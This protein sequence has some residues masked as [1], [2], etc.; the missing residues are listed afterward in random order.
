MILERACLVVPTPVCTLYG[1]DNC[2]KHKLTHHIV[3]LHDSRPSRLIP[4]LL[5]AY[6]ISDT[7]EIGILKG[8]L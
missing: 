8:R 2:M 4:L 6:S 7:R 5:Q 3:Y 1:S